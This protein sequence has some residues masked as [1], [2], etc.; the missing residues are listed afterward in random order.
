MK[1]I[2]VLQLKNITNIFKIILHVI[3]ILYYIYKNYNYIMLIYIK[4]F[5]SMSVAVMKHT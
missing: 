4:G 2:L 3:F 5:S 1:I